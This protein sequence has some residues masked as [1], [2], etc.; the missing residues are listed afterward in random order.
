[1]QTQLLQVLQEKRKTVLFITHSVEEAVFLSDRV[2]AITSRP[3][4]TK[5]TFD[6][7]FPSP[8][9]DDLKASNE[10]LSLREKLKNEV[11]QEYRMQTEGS[12]GK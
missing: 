5:N 9:Q 2:V 6:I 8:R 4:R 3:A 11:M 1:M 10:F 12:D 7:P